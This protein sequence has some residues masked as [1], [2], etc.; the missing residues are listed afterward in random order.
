MNPFYFSYASVDN[1]VA[2]AGPTAIFVPGRTNRNDTAF[3][4]ARTAGAEVYP[5]F[6]LVE[7][8]NTRVSGLDQEFYMGDYNKVPLWGNNRSGWNNQNMLVDIREGSAWI[9]YAVDYIGKLAASGKFDG[10][11]LDV[12]GGQLWMSN[13]ANWPKDE[14]LEWANGAVATVKALSEAVPENFILVNNNT[15]QFASAG[16]RYV[17]GICIEHPK[18]TNWD[19]FKVYANK[20]YNSRRRRVLV[21]NNTDLQSD[22]WKAVPGVTHVSTT[23]AAQY[24]SAVPN[25]ISRTDLRPSEDKDY[26]KQLEAK[27]ADLNELHIKLINDYKLLEQENLDL[28]TEN[29]SLRYKINNAVLDLGGIPSG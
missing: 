16:E 25:K 17:S 6:N 10:V 24:S 7:R 23:T 19:F 5:Y 11:F 4:L 21:V 15:W 27:Y 26:I 3:T 1:V 28:V 8:P 22:F 20:A 29:E 14:Q 18:E 13:Y 12:I 2:L 9:R